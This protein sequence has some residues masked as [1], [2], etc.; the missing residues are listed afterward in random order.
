MSAPRQIPDKA[1]AECGKAFRPHS[2]K[3]FRNPE[4]CHNKRCASKRAY[5]QGRCSKLAQASARASS[6]RRR[7]RVEKT[8]RKQYGELSAREIELFNLGMKIGYDRGYGIAYNRQRRQEGTA[9]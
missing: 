7:R 8:T 6:L 2:W 9:A 5:R 4:S 3:Q 1:C